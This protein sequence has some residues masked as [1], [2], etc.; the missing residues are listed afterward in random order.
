MESAPPKAMNFALGEL[1]FPMPE[2]LKKE[3]CQLLSS[4]TPCYTPNAGLVE[5]R[6]AISALYPNASANSICICNGAEEAL[7][8]SLLALTNPGDIIAIPDP[9]YTAYPSLGKLHSAVVKRLPF[10]DDLCSIDWTQWE[11]ILSH[12]VKLILLSSPSNPSGYIYT[13]AD[14][15]LLGD[16]CNRLGIILLV[17]EIY[18]TLHFHEKPCDKWSYYFERVI[19]INGLSKSHCLSGWRIGWLHAPLDIIGSMIKAKQYIS[20]CSHWLSQKLIPFAL[21][22]PELAEDI[23]QQLHNNQQYS[24]QMLDSNLPSY[25][26]KAHFPSASPYI[27]LK[28]NQED[29]LL[30]AKALATH[31]IIT[32][33]GSAFGEVSRGWIRMNIGVLPEVLEQGLALIYSYREA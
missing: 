9:D 1:S 10:M 4:S 21:S 26:N 16:I 20:T 31:G 23:R 33:P 19:R 15:K 13:E 17:D 24:K 25:C 14:M 3:A 8:I 32:V 2:A 11:Q 30:V 5:A 28:L 18:S 27:M 6:Q 7:Y 22:H 12:D 29:D